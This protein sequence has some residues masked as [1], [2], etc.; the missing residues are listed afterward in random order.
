[1][2]NPIARPF[3]QAIG[4]GIQVVGKPH[5]FEFRRVGQTI[6]IEMMDL[7]VL[8]LVA[9]HERERRTLDRAGMAQRPQIT[10]DEGGFAGRKL[11]TEKESQTGPR[12]GGNTRTE[13]LHGLIGIHFESERDGLWHA[14]LSAGA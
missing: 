12:A 8:K 10:P 7:A 5:I 1:M 4:M 6:E 14:C 13:G 3:N 9:F 11:A 2:V